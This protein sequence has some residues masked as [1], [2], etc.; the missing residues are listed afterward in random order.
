M[1]G[2]LCVVTDQAVLSGALGGLLFAAQP[3][4]EAWPHRVGEALGSPVAVALAVSG[5]LRGPLFARAG[6]VARMGW[7]RSSGA[8]LWPGRPG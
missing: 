4:G 6:D 3:W 1:D 7:S 5:L 8:Q 2:V